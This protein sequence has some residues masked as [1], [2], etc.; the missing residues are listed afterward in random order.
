MIKNI[1]LVCASSIAVVCC[2][3]EEKRILPEYKKEILSVVNQ[4]RSQEDF[5]CIEKLDEGLWCAVYDGHGGPFVARFLQQNLHY[6]FSASKKTDMREKMIDAFTTCDEQMIQHFQHEDTTDGMS[7]YGYCGSTAVVAFIQNNLIHFAHTG[8][9]RGILVHDG[10]VVFATTDHK[11]DNPN[12]LLRMQL[13]G[14]HLYITGIHKDT[15]KEKLIT[16]RI[17]GLAVSRAF[18]DYALKK[19][20][21]NKCGSPVVIAQPEYSC[22]PLNAKS[23]LIL[24][25]DGLWDVVSN[26]EVVEIIEDNKEKTIQN[27]TN[28]LVNK[29][30]VKGS[31]DNITVMLID[32]LS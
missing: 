14:A 22:I 20:L 23:T 15:L 16:A 18:G 25:S 27:S 30:I 29:A 17:E 26:Q 4:R 10:K 9:S 3:S 6:Y 12:E 11:V 7:C 21:Q 8:D 32:L 28:F 1:V 5:A 24:A 19:K 13:A 2:A 31:S